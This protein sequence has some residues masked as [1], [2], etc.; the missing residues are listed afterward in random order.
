MTVMDEL[1]GQK[2]QSEGGVLRIIEFLFS[3]IAKV[4]VFAWMIQFADMVGW[5]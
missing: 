5:S 4:F 1:L 3:E 2:K